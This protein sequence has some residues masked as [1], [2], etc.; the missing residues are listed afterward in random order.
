[1]T[2]ENKSQ[3]REEKQKP[4]RDRIEEDMERWEG[5][6]NSEAFSHQGCSSILAAAIASGSLA[7]II[8]VKLL[9]MLFAKVVW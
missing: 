6:E 3:S 9:S 2:E 7:S 4:E 5:V 1:M 8:G